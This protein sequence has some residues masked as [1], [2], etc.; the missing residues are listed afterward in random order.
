[1]LRG[2]RF[3]NPLE[4]DQMTT[5]GFIWMIRETIFA[6]RPLMKDGAGFLSFIDWR[7]WPTLL[8]AVESTNLRVNQMIVWDKRTYGLGHGFRSQHEL[9]LCASKG[10]PRVVDR[11]IPNVIQHR[12]EISDDHPSPKPPGLIEQ[13]LKVVTDEG[14]L[15]VDPFAGTGATLRAAANMN[16]RAIGI[17]IEE[18]YCEVA[19]RRLEQGALP[20]TVAKARAGRGDHGTE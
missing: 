19:V 5:P 10:V 3:K 16:R 15:I 8:G 20:L 2:G 14:D 1:M 18:R 13:L 7:Q 11:S 6:L 9:V 17:E 12:R 4:N